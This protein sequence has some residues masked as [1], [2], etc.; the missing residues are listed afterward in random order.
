MTFSQRLESLIKEKE[1]T[2]YRLSKDIGVHQ[3]TIKNWLSESSS[4]NGEKL[5]KLAAYFRVDVDYLLGKSEIK[6]ASV[7]TYPVGGILNFPIMAS[8]KAG[9]GSS[10]VEDF[11]GETEAVPTA[12][13]K[14]YSVEE[15]RMLRVKGDSMYPRICDG[16]LVLVHIQPSVDSGDTAVVLY[17]GDEATIKKV[18]YQPGCDWVE[19]IPAN[20]EY[21]TKRIE[22]PD[23]ELCRIFG[24]VIRLIREI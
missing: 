22:G 3:T 21:Q 6:N 9:Y 18:R 4:P 24:R 10:A 1:I 12:F 20:P 5:Q 11:T 23:L 13:L 19:L 16:D 7:K 2:A 14:G 15:C 8:V 17:D